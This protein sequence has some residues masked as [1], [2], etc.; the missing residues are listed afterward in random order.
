MG[1][2]VSQVKS[3]FHTPG[4]VIVLAIAQPAINTPDPISTQSPIRAR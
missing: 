3:T 2:A 4:I 1:V